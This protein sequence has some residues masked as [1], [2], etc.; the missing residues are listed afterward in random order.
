MKHLA[1]WAL[2]LASR[3]IAEPP[4][5]LY[6]KHLASK[7]VSWRHE[8]IDN[9]ELIPEAAG[10]VDDHFNSTIDWALDGDQRVLA[11]FRSIHTTTGCR[12]GCSPV[13]FHLMFGENG[14]PTKVI[15]DPQHPLLKVYHQPFSSDDLRRLQTLITD[16]QP[17]LDPLR[18]PIDLTN[19]HGHFPPQTWTYYKDVLIDGGA[20]T[21]FVVY[22]AARNTQRYVDGSHRRPVFEEN[23]KRFIELFQ[24]HQGCREQISPCLAG[25]DTYLDPNLELSPFDRQQINGFF[26]SLVRRALVSAKAADPLFSEALECVKK[27]PTLIRTNPNDVVDLLRQLATST[28]GSE[29]VDRFLSHT[30]FARWLSASQR[31][32]LPLLA[33]LMTDS[34][35]LGALSETEERAFIK[36]CAIDPKLLEQGALQCIRSTVPS[37]DRAARFLAALRVK[38]PD[39]ELIGD[40]DRFIRENDKLFNQAFDHAKQRHVQELRQEFSATP[41]T[42]PTATG[43]CRKSGAKVSIPLAEGKK[44]VYIFFASWCAHCQQTVEAIVKRGNPAF[45]DIIQLVEVHGNGSEHYD[46]FAKTTGLSGSSMDV[47]ALDDNNGEFYK[48][49]ALYAVPKVIMTDDKGRIINFNLNIPLDTAAGERDIFW[50]LEHYGFGSST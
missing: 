37:K 26:M 15:Q 50:L 38:F 34:K 23:R 6:S 31:K 19:N 13:V 49:M 9:M 14:A 30:G 36:F 2:L 32:F 20:Y 43:Q 48:K 12:S 22:S 24:K 40:L 4:Y 45:Q 10:P 28:E 16:S 35:A 44:H 41:M 39:H 7:P 21:T 3:A 18:S 11:G 1:V 46:Y 47:I 17:K 29:K 8:R 42:F 25:A 5:S 33:K 27:H